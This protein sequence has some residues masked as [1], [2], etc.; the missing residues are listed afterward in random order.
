[1]EN[2]KWTTKQIILFAVS[3]LFNIYGLLTILYL[4]GLNTGLKYMDNIGN[5]LFK[6]LVVISFMMPGILLFGIFAQTFVGKLKKI[7][8]VVNCTYSTILTI[9][10]FLTM[11]LGF[12]V[13]QGVNIPMV[14]DICLD[15]IK[16]F[17]AV[18]LQYIFFSLGTLVGIIFLAEPIIACYLT[19][20]DIEP[21]IKNIL[22][23]FKKKT[24]N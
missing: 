4:N 10:L 8:V 14:S 19:V 7:L 5:M 3:V 11:A 6:Y 21:T 22:G 24:K 15:I 17:P 9:P 16:L 1:M 12:A 23:V 13:I 20:K 2:K 18:A